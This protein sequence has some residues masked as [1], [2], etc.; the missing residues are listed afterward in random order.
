MSLAAKLRSLFSEPPPEYV[1]EISEAGLA[2]AAAAQPS[3]IQWAPLAE[4]VVTVDPI[5]DNIREPEMYAAAVRAV[6]P[7]ASGK[8]QKQRCAA[9]VLPDYCVRLAVLDFDTFPSD[10]SEQLALV[11]FRLKRAVAFDIESAAVACFPQK[12]EGS[13]KIDVAIA[14]VHRDVLARYEAPFRALG[15]Q[16]GSVT[17]S[18]LAA[19]ALSPE[20]GYEHTSPSVVAKVT[21][22][23]LAVSLLEGQRLRMIRCVEVPHATLDEAMEILIPT[24]AF[25]EDELG[26]RPQVLHVAGLARSGGGA[27]EEISAQLGL[28]VVPLRSRYGVPGPFNSGL[29]GALE[30]LELS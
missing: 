13:G 18:N 24:F 22:R 26:A 23:I 19:L 10:L 6:V 20:A 5:E 27:L 28:P 15:F 21:G 3:Q 12:R 4:G 17:P 30:T 25:C 14:A 9:L 29:L 2:W 7:A 1:F 8:R 11:R 16:V